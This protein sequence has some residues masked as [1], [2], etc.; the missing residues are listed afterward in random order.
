MHRPNVSTYLLSSAEK[1]KF[2]KAN[3][4]T[5]YL[6]QLG[7]TLFNDDDWLLDFN[8]GDAMQVV[9]EFNFREF[10]VMHHLHA[11]ES[12]TILWM[13]GMDFDRTHW[14]GIDAAAF[15]A[16]LRKW[17]HDVLGRVGVITFSGSYDLAYMLKMMYDN[18]YKLPNT[19]A[20]FNNIVKS[21]VGKMLY[22]VK[23]MAR[24]YPSDLRG[25]LEL[26]ARK[27][28]VRCVVGEVH[29]HYRK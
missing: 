2:I 25:G 10:D 16:R 27:L 28:G 5:L 26:V 22:D 7:L 24:H 6:V 19:I 21:V 9:W 1:Y 15:K 12:I 3:I 29:Q 17:L 20:Q 4:N 8:T 13:K 18:S 14:H 23:E 11:L